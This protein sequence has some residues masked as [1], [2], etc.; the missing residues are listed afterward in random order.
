[1]ALEDVHTHT[2]L[3]VLTTRMTSQ[4]REDHY[5]QKYLNECGGRLGGRDGGSIGEAGGQQR[6]G[7][8]RRLLCQEKRLSRIRTH[9][10]LRKNLRGR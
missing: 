1:M 10:E 3:A 8:Q 9:W 2:P 5:W 6:W 7:R 4:G